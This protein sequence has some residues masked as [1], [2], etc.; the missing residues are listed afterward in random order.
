MVTEAGI[1][2]LRL[3]QAKVNRKA[4]RLTLKLRSQV[5]G[6]SA[7]EPAAGKVKLKP[8]DIKVRAQKNV[9]VVFSTKAFGNMRSA[10]FV[11]RFLAVPAGPPPTPGLLQHPPALTPATAAWRHAHR[12]SQ[13]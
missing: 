11:V 7:A 6:T 3:K 2:V 5:D 13:K 9:T 4:K 12:F 1:K 8:R 10:S